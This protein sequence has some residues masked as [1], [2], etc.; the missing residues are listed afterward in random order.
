MTG[1][2]GGRRPRDLRTEL[3]QDDGAIP[4]SWIPKVGD[5]LV[6]ELVRY[7]RGTTPFG[8]KVIAVIADEESGELRGFWLLHE[9]ARQE[10]QDQ[11]PRP[12]ERVGI[13]RLPDTEKGF[14][15]FR[16]VVDRDAAASVPDFEASAPPAAAPPAGRL[17]RPAGPHERP[18]VASPATDRGALEPPPPG[19]GDCPFN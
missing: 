6:G 8:S 13:K 16:V 12:G 17:E 7:D 1:P 10:F 9:V 15:R 3:D 4:S 19:D 5:T 18:A 2:N 11:K 14:H